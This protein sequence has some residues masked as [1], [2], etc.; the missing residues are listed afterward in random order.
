M[1]FNAD[2]IRKKLADLSGKSSKKNV[3]WRPEEGKTYTVRF[4]PLPKSSDGSG[5][6][7]LWF[8]YGVGN[9]SGLL[10]PYQFGKPDPFQELINKLRADD[11]KDSYELAKKLYPKMRAFAAVLVRGE[12][13]KGIRLWSF[14]KSVYQ[15]ILNIM[16]D[17]DYG[18]IMDPKKGYDIK[19]SCEKAA[20]KQFADT[21]IRP[22]PNPSPLHEDPTKA[23]EW[24][25]SIPSLDDVYSEKSYDELLKLL[26][27]WINPGSSLE[28]SGVT[29]SH[30]SSN[31]DDSF[32]TKSTASSKKLDDAFAELDDL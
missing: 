30:A 8:Y 24:M 17:A 3:M 1:A 18:D 21:S 32:P 5:L 19:V 9:N 13:D 12:E 6:R 15:D 10:A 16:L 11:A 23:K 28:T 29:R 4:L 7:D 25:T 2:A 27:D 26:N 31:D 20:G 14:G 22:R